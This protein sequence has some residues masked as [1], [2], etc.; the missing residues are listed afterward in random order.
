MQQRV[1]SFTAE[2]NGIFGN[3]LR[4]LLKI[5]IQ[6]KWMCQLK[7]DSLASLVHNNFFRFVTMTTGCAFLCWIQWYFWKFSTTIIKD[8]YTDIVN[9]V[10]QKYKQ[11]D[12]QTNAEVCCPCKHICNNKLSQSNEIHSYLLLRFN[13]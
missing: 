10:K 5:S 11:T 9:C 7:R 8:F 3:F 12:R 6:I 4:R 1:A 13:I 2:S